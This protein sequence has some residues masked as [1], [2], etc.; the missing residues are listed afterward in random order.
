MLDRGRLYAVADVDKA[1]DKIAFGR[2]V[3]AATPFEL[4]VASNQL[5]WMPRGGAAITPL[6]PLEGDAPVEALRASP[7]GAGF[8]VVFRRG[9]SVYIGSLSS[10]MKALGPLQETRGLGTQVGAPT[11]A[12]SG[13]S[14]LALWADR[15]NASDG[16]ALRMRRSPPN[17]VLGDPTEASAEEGATLVGQLVGQL[18][19]AVRGWWPQQP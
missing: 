7:D 8:A 17:G 19:E 12:T 10:S 13:G 14:T 9:A 15:A 5:S 3:P 16:W 18:V 1:G 6:W 4:G 11:I 2:T